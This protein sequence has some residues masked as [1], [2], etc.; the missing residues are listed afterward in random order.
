MSSFTLR[1]LGAFE[2]RIG[3]GPPLVLP[4]RK[5]E[6]LLAYLALPPGREHPRDQ[7]TAL[8]WPDAG[9]RRARHSLRQAL[10]S[11]RK[12]LPAGSVAEELVVEADHVALNPREVDVDAIT[13]E[14]RVREGTLAA[15][16]PAIDLYRGDL[17]EGL[18]FREPAFEEWLVPERERLRELA[19]KALAK[20][21]GLHERG[22]N[23]EASIEATQRLLAL[24]P[25]REEAHRMLMRLYARD[26]RRGAAL[27][28]YQSCLSVLKRDLGAE[29]EAETRQLYH[30]LLRQRSTGSRVH[31]LP[32][33]ERSPDRDPALAPWGRDRGDTTL[34]GRDAELG[35][36]R[37]SLERARR[38]QGVLAAVIGE[39]GAG[40]SHLL[41]DF[42]AEAVD[43]DARVLIGRAYEMEGALPLGPWIDAFR[44]GL[45]PA[46]PELEGFSPVWK[47]HL[48]RLLP[49]L[50]PEPPLTPAGDGAPRLFEAIA[51]LL[52]HL[53]SRR[54]V[55]VALEDLHWADAMSLNLLS[56]VA[57]RISGWP[58]MVVATARDEELTASATQVLRALDVEE[59]V[60]S[61]PVGR[62]SRPATLTLVRALGRSGR[63]PATA[64]QGSRIWA[65]SEGNPFMV[66]ETMRVVDEVGRASIAGRLPLPDRIQKT[67]IGRLE[68]LTESGRRLAAAAAVIGR[69]FE[70]TLLQRTAGLRERQT[71]E[72]MEELVRRGVLRA[73]GDQF[74]FTHDSIRK[75]A[76]EQLLALRRDTLHLAVAR[77]LE[78]LY[79]EHLEGVHDRLA[80]HYSRTSHAA[81]AVAYLTRS[82]EGASRR[83]AAG[84]AV[85]SLE[86][87]LTH[88]ERLPA[89]KRDRA[90][91][92]VSLR[93]AVAL[94]ILGRFDEILKRLSPLSELVECL[95]DP[96]V[97]GAYHARLALTHSNVGAHDE[98]RRSAHR[99]IDAAM[100]SGEDVTRGQAHYVLSIEGFSGG[101]AVDGLADGRRAVELLER[102]GER[103]WAGQAY[104]DRG[105]ESS[106]ARG[107][108][109]RAP[110]RGASEKPRYRPRR[111]RARGFRLD[112]GRVDSRDP[113][114]L[115]RGHG[116]RSAESEAFARP[117]QQGDGAGPR[118]LRGA[119]ERPRRWRPPGQGPPRPGAIRAAAVT[120][121][122][123]AKRD[124][125]LS[126]GGPPARR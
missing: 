126:G 21:A 6:A 36:L 66:V 73:S 70:F 26:G 74:E 9:D 68:R 124:A 69:E 123:P 78:A 50:W 92:D 120:V 54:P 40:K 11:L 2:L 31:E 80:Y 72:A 58:V 25:L 51:E 15:L 14:H 43:A 97:G 91:L 5:A 100:R 76:Y 113:R 104:S 71:A 29:P 33:S 48:R 88:A 53:A 106:P 93:L 34:I 105:P 107:L 37:Q 119:R 7:L 49:D 55:L 89:S 102:T 118:G 85:R 13:F 86:Q 8:L 39:A 56:F 67:I 47:V 44:G 16:E 30:E 77:S 111:S 83:H 125:D 57:R 61:V 103:R 87:A 35:R 96:S 3:S 19:Q 28:Q 122:D 10:F 115:D 94:S 20:L 63:R 84:D 60:V 65:L 81:K 62:L 24:D 46:L 121:W 42:L 114:R 59:R 110:G 45:G 32:P 1:V 82:A 98:A 75:V 112:G 18:A 23:I 79:A 17:L 95:D 99:A 109:A 27:R 117:R 41:R 12:A 38:G 101:R 116:D 64:R 4:T 22:G 90:R 52:R 108:R